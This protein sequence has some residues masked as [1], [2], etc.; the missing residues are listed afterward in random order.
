MRASMKG[1]VAAAVVLSVCHVLTAAPPLTSKEIQRAIDE[2][3][4]QYLGDFPPGIV[5]TDRQYF[6]GSVVQD[7]R[8]KYLRVFDS[9]P[10]TRD[11]LQLPFEPPV[12]P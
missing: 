4:K 1:Q 6:S 3:A 8:D 10:A 5:R 12:T 9:F 7:I 2:A 11:L